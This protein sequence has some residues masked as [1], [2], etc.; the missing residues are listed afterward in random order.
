MHSFI[1]HVQE[2][3][4]PSIRCFLFPAISLQ[5]LSFPTLATTGYP[6]LSPLYLWVTSPHSPPSFLSYSNFYNYA[7]LYVCCT[8]YYSSTM[9]VRYTYLNSKVYVSLYLFTFTDSKLYFFILHNFYKN[10]SE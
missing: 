3:V 1:N 2:D 10:L 8:T 4:L 5:L 7:C 9:Y 6:S